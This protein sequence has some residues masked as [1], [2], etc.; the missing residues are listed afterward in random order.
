MKPANEWDEDYLL[1]LPDFEPMRMDFKARKALD[2]TLSNVDENHIKEQLSVALSAFANT[3]GGLIIYGVKDPQPGKPLTIDDGGIDMKM[4]GRSTKEWLEDVIPN[5]TDYP[6]LGFEV[7]P[8]TGKEGDSQILSGRA[9]FIVE[10]PDSE[11]APHQARDQKY[12]I[13]AGSKS[14]PIGHRIVMD[15]LGRRQYPD[16][17][18]K[19]TFESEL[20][21]GTKTEGVVITEGMLPHSVLKVIAINEGRIYAQYVNCQIDIPV[22]LISQ[23]TRR[24]VVIERI[25]NDAYYK[26][27]LDNTRTASGS[28][29]FFPILPSQVFEWTWRIPA[30]FLPFVSNSQSLIRWKIFADNS[31]LKEGRILVKEIPNLVK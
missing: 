28:S 8:I 11:K 2:L 4:K 19:L 24:R 27:H 14:V 13:R 12:Y 22:D 25:D 17:Q 31:P 29:Y 1:N 18:L 15:I 7:H 9:V 3:G 20:H 21:Y 16:I 5:L 10:V 26:W 23:D 6:I 30:D